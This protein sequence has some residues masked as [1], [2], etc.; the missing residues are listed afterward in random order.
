LDSDDIGR[1]L[2]NLARR[3]AA[4]D[5]YPNDAVS[6]FE[7][8]TEALRNSCWPETAWRFSTL[9][10]G[11]GPVELVFSSLDNALRYTIEAAGPELDERARLDAVVAL[12]RRLGHT[13]PAAR[14]MD[15]WRDLQAQ[16]RLV[17]GA[18]LS[19]RRGHGGERVKIYVE[20]PAE[21]HPPEPAHAAFRPLPGSIPHMIGYEPSGG[22]TELYFSKS[23]ADPHELRSL[24]RLVEPADRRETLLTSFADVCGMPLDAALRWITLGYSVAY[25]SSGETPQIALFVRAKATLGGA[26]SVRHKLVALQS[27]S[28]LRTSA[29]RDLLAP[30]ADRD[31]PDHGILT[32]A[33]TPRGQLELRVGINAV[34]LARIL[35]RCR[36]A[37]RCDPP[38]S[39]KPESRPYLAAVPGESSRY[40]QVCKAND[41][42]ERREP[43]RSMLAAIRFLLD[44]QDRDGAWRD[45]QLPPG[46]SDAWVTAYVGAVLARAACSCPLLG[47][48]DA[49][50]AAAR[51]LE[52]QRHRAGGWS[53]NA[54]CPVDC[55]STARGILFFRS[56]D[57]DARPIDYA[58]L[59]R[60]H[61]SDGSFATYRTGDAEHGWNRAHPD[62]S[63]L[64]LRALRPVLS[65]DHSTIRR[66]FS[67]LAEHLRTPNALD[68]YWWISQQYMAKE[69][70]LLRLAFPAEFRRLPFSVDYAVAFI[71][72]VLPVE[73][74][75]DRR[76]D[77]FALALELEAR[78]LAGEDASR[79]TAL[80]QCLERQQHSD[81]SW[82][83]AP[84][85][86]FTDRRALRIGD[87]H[88]LSSLVVSD[89]RQLFTTATALSA[90]NAAVEKLD[91]LPAPTKDGALP[92]S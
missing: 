10:Q 47:I 30:I 11:G 64:A 49:V 46:R 18:W 81:G 71:Q 8:C 9:M 60:F 58:A 80:A 21:T 66:G 6:S 76:S 23:G 52:Q 1:K 92:F 55:D 17:W 45:F 38:R 91:R 2:S 43:P 34:A 79:L 78:V 41:A 70:L 22:R 28:G 40:K 16:S 56:I 57:S 4:Y 39:T 27:Q 7:I 42:A 73:L 12:M 67:Y 48:D 33:L 35:L 26:S 3:I 54:A 36:D 44:R 51:F 72:A 59:A 62:V 77:C 75:R 90:L 20:V 15:A 65:P 61:L 53:Y 88:F 69:L 83:S 14:L 13:P 89:D 32:I 82:P 19:V 24:T 84:I 86:R 87:A 85:M 29:Y 50:T 37:P 31:L 68:S 74:D 25:C 5:T 63:V